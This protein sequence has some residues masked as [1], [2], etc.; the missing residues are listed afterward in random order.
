MTDLLFSFNLFIAFA[1][2][3]FNT[4]QMYLVLLEEANKS[5]HSDTHHRFVV[6]VYVY[7]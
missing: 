7:D 5:D 6:Y 1:A 3:W 2:I 4:R